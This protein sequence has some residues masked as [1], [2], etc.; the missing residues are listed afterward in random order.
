[1]VNDCFAPL[2][3]NLSSF[4]L[5]YLISILNLEG[6][7][8]CQLIFTQS[9]FPWMKRSPLILGEDVS[10]SQLFPLNPQWEHFQYKDEKPSPLLPVPPLHLDDL[11]HWMDIESP[12]TR[13]SC[14]AHSSL[15]WSRKT[16]LGG[17]HA[18]PPT[19]MILLPSLSQAPLSLSIVP[20]PMVLP[21]TEI[22]N[23]M[24]SNSPTYMS[25]HR[26]F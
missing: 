2:V 6:G 1:M 5:F 8:P 26:L 3:K 13:S 21:R 25:Q 12:P 24:G 15:I 11:M 20:T 17:P 23:I 14:E 7:C 16:D 19:P 22:V 4:S 9:D 18:L 10:W